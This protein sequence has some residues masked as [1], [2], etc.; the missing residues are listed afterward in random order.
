MKHRLISRIL[1]LLE[2]LL[3]TII[4]LLVL[5]I[6]SWALLYIIAAIFDL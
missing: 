6:G 3:V 4:A 1:E 2:S 5:I